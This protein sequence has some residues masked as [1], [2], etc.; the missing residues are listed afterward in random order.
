MSGAVGAASG[1][2]IGAAIAAAL[3]KIL[4]DLNKGMTDSLKNSKVHQRRSKKKVWPSGIDRSG[5][6]L[7]APVHRVGIVAPEHLDCRSG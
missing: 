2:G 3:S 4:G 7:P 6:L 5:G 1:V